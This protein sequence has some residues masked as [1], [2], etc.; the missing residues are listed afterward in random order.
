METNA[1]TA[2]RNDEEVTKEKLVRDIKVV[3]RDAEELIKATAGD[4][5]E[6]TKEAR[7]RLGAAME[8][9]RESCHKLEAKAIA[10][11][12]ATDRII[13]ENPYQSIGL[14]FGLGLLVGVLVN[15][16]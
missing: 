5:S 3:L 15:R 6:K 2:E 8:R 12:K 7:V 1:G 13:R 11:A 16:K 4:L 10:G 9:A 14:A